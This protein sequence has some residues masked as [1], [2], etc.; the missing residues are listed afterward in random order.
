MQFSTKPRDEETEVRVPT[1][2]IDVIFLLLIFFMMTY[3]FPDIYKRKLDVKLPQAKAADVERAT[4][5]LVV[6]MDARGRIALNGEEMTVAVLEERLKRPEA[7]GRTVVIKADERL[8]HGAVTQVLGI[9]RDAG[10]VD[11]AIAVR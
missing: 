3:T 5:K 8:S 10:L 11:V 9:C 1:S 2:L 4:K 6:E 7:K